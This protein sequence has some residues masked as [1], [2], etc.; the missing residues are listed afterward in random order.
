[1]DDPGKRPDKDY[2]ISWVREYGKGRV[3]YCALG[4]A[5]PTYWNPAV[6]KHF[7]AGIQF[8]IGD[9]KAEAKPVAANPAP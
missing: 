9:L 8:A 5:A 1:M 4:H 7:L 6:L 2:A 3:F